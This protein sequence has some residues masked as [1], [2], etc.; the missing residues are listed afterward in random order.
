MKTVYLAGPI[1]GCTEGEAKD[2]RQYIDG[3]FAAGIY[4]VSPLRCEPCY[5]ERYDMDTQ[6]HDHRFGSQRAV[7]GKNEFDV[8]NCDIVLAYLPAELNERRPSYGTVIEIA[9]ARM[10]GKQVILVTDDEA[11]RKHPLVDHC[12][13]WVLDSLEDAA[14]V[15]NGVMEVYA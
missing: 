8:R 13:N 14:D 10:L 12:A 4:G 7:A 3:K 9:W 11:L 1:A 15:I 6:K 5:A 2:W